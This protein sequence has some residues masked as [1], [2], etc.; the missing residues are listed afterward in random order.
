MG[1]SSKLEFGYHL[2]V[3]QSID[4]VMKC[5]GKAAELGFDL[6][7]HQDHFLVMSDESGC[8][9]ECWVFLTAV[10]VKYNVKVMP[11]VLCSLFR[12]PALLAKM[13]T[14]LDQLSK[15]RV[16]LGIGACWWREEFE[17]YGYPWEDARTRVDKTEE[18]I[19]IL[20]ALW[21]EEA[22]NFKGRYWSLVNCRLVPR[23]YQK[24]HP[25]II[26][27]GHG[28]RMLRITARLCDGWVGVTKDLDAYREKMEYVKKYLAKP[29]E[30]FIWGN[31]IDVR[32]GDKAE[33]L[34][35]LVEDFVKL[36]VNLVIFFVHPQPKNYELLDEVGKVVAHF[37]G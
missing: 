6:I 24:P 28:R 29:P 8:R 20:K 12:N 13:V 5:A 16:Y 17:A 11:L 22:V 2:P 9:P 15:G 19:K 26:N 14:T 1:T 4:Y 37:K 32:E 10:A 36:G 21:T 23:P 31:V 25:P 18:V 7:S 27:G 30:E 3:T 34:V 35:S 33:D